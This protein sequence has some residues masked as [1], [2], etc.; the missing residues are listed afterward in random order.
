MWYIFEKFLSNLNC[1]LD[2]GATSVTEPAGGF[3]FSFFGNSYG[4]EPYKQN[5]WTCSASKFLAFPRLNTSKLRKP[6][7]WLKWGPLKD[8]HDVPVSCATRPP[9]TSDPVAT[10]FVYCC[11]EITIAQTPEGQVLLCPELLTWKAQHMTQC[12]L[13]SVGTLQTNTEVVPSCGQDTLRRWPVFISLLFFPCL[14]MLGLVPLGD[15]KQWYKK[16]LGHLTE[17]G[18]IFPEGETWS[19]F[20]S[21]LHACKTPF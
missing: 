12:A 3:F 14:F 16:I 18:G 1:P 19:S 21:D 11:T 8:R 6:Q 2:Q 9:A 5:G 7:Q 20:W 10:G 15:S 17:M 13:A 4:E